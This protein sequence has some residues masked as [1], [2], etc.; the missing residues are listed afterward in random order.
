MQILQCDCQT[1]IA[2]DVDI[3]EA[4]NAIEGLANVFAAGCI[5]PQTSGRLAAEEYQRQPCAGELSEM[6]N[7]LGRHAVVRTDYHSSET[8]L[9]RSKNTASDVCGGKIEVVGAQVLVGIP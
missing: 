8:L 4:G 9:F 6:V 7:S 2:Y 1:P 5:E 3:P